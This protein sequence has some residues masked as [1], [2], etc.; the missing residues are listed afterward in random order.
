MHLGRLGTQR[1]YRIVLVCL[2]SIAIFTPISAQ[3]GKKFGAHYLKEY[4]AKNA[5]ETAILDTLMQYETAFN[6]HD[7]QKMI[8]LFTKDGIYM[9]CGNNYIRYSISSKD[10]QTVLQRNF[11]LFGFETYYDPQIKVNGDKA[12]I[13]LLLETGAYLAD[14]QFTLQKVNQR[15]LVL[16]AEYTND[17][18]K[19]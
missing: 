11:S 8:A 10:C 6:A 3:Q 12:A 14:Y 2:F 5:D 17:R 9:P 19:E 7:L 13:N 4:H 18:N 15:W 16:D 1:F